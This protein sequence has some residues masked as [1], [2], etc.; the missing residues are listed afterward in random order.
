MT[1]KN[2][3]LFIFQALEECMDSC[4]ENFQ[5]EINRFKF[6]NELIKLVSKKHDGD[7]TPK[8]VS[9]RVRSQQNRKKAIFHPLSFQ[10]LNVLLT[11]TNKYDHL[12]KIKEAYSLL[13][14]QGIEHEPPKDI[15]SIRNQ[16]K[17][18]AQQRRAPDNK[19]EIKLKKLLQSNRPEDRTMANLMIKNI[20]REEERKM[21]LKNRRIV[22]LEKVKSMVELVPCKMLNWF[23]FLVGTRKYFFAERNV[24]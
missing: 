15:V 9:D 7:K 24:K 10:I 14:S 2:R 6:L 21:Q 4:G 23:S 22:E 17:T 18:D 5:I 16:P 11:W 1:F 20:Y 12:N 8:E 3:F 19:N 13:K